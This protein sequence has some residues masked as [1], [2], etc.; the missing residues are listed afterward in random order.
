MKQSFRLVNSLLR[1]YGESNG[2]TVYMLPSRVP[3]V[4]KSTP[5]SA[6]IAL[7]DCTVASACAL[8]FPDHECVAPPRHFQSCETYACISF[9]NSTQHLQ[10]SC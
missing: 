2:F 10:C 6:I 8:L 3:S 7:A 5:C 4:L 1:L 9:W